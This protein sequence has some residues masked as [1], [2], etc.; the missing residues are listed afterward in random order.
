MSNTKF[1]TTGR[2]LVGGNYFPYSQPLP[3]NR[4]SLGAGQG[5][6]FQ[7]TRSSESLRLLLEGFD[8]KILEAEQR[9]DRFGRLAPGWSAADLRVQ[10]LRRARSA[11]QR[12]LD[13]VLQEITEEEQRAPLR[14]TTH[15][16]WEA[17]KHCDFQRRDYK[18]DVVDVRKVNYFVVDNQGQ[19]HQNPYLPDVEPNSAR[20]TTFLSTNPCAS[21]LPAAQL[22]LW[23]PNPT[24]HKA[25]RRSHGNWFGAGALQLDSHREYL[26]QQK[27]ERG[28]PRA[29]SFLLRRRPDVGGAILWS[30]LQE[31]QHTTSAL[32]PQMQSESVEAMLTARRGYLPISNTMKSGQERVASRR[33]DPELLPTGVPGAVD[34]LASPRLER[35]RA[36]APLGSPYAVDPANMLESPRSVQSKRSAECN[37]GSAGGE[38]V[39]LVPTFDVPSKEG[40]L[41]KKRYFHEENRGKVYGGSKR[42]TDG[43]SPVVPAQEKVNDLLGRKADGGS[44]CLWVEELKETQRVVEQQCAV[45]GKHASELQRRAP[46]LSVWS[47]VRLMSPAFVSRHHFERPDLQL[48]VRERARGS[49]MASCLRE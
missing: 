3:A 45:R 18:Q 34:L 1:H 48:K 32:E 47:S 31:S 23:G 21:N 14:Q 7:L 28:G 30:A 4:A 5:P 13:Q 12:E 38:E 10:E 27:S 6:L 41:R 35:A 17:A 2:S 43:D 22:T 37:P 8:E 24:F 40:T 42:K 29:A 33:L 16:L 39:Q 9:R 36:T 15:Q 44:N 26:E 19:L 46:A 20:K 49:R 11:R 25:V